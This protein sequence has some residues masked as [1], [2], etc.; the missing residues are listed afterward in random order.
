M[1]YTAI[2]ITPNHDCAYFIQ[3]FEA[4]PDEMW[5]TGVNYPARCA[6]NHCQGQETI[7]FIKLF[8]DAFPCESFL[9]S[10]AVIN[11]G[12]H[13]AYKQPTPKARILAALRDIKAKQEAQP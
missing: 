3:K 1:N 11:D 13:P 2:A 12:R 6:I 4:I 5:T 7:A 9:Y 8:E 10:A